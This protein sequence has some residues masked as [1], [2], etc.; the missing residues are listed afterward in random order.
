MREFQL[1][2]SIGANN[3]RH[4]GR[5]DNVKLA[6]VELILNEAF[7]R[8]GTVTMDVTVGPEIGPQ[9][10]QVRTEQGL[11]IITLGVDDGEDYV[12]RSYS[13]GGQKADRVEILGDYWASESVCSDIKMVIQV[14]KEFL[15]TGDVSQEV[16]N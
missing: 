7:E 16:L 8:S 13:G 6:D 12:V 4:G 14:F 10:L 11:S 2:W 3:D 9:S 5:K 15:G 1:S